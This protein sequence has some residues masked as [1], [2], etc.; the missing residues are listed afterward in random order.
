R[1]GPPRPPLL[2][3]P[4]LSRSYCEPIP[5]FSAV[6]STGSTIAFPSACEKVLDTEVARAAVD[7]ARCPTGD[8]AV[9]GNCTWGTAEQVGA[10]VRSEE[11]TSDLQSRDNLV[12]R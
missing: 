5:A 8:G 6:T 3:D 9:K 7:A 1:L 12:R 10:A 4:P 11:H 2:P